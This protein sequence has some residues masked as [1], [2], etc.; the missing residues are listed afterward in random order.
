MFNIIVATDKNQGIGKNGKLPW[1]LRADMQFFKK[2]TTF[3]PESNMK[4]AVIMGRKTYESIPLKFRPL[5][6][7]LN[8]VLTKNHEYKQDNVITAHQ[9]DE[10]LEMLDKKSDIY[11]VFIIGGGEIYKEA[12]FHSQCKR[13]YR[14]V[15]NK[16]FNCDTFFPK[17]ESKF[18]L[19][20]ESNLKFENEISY[21]FQTW[22]K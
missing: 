16:N 22:S 2:T 8:I 4:N 19:E 11:N 18:Y 14:T 3:C 6:N 12:I 13:V 9:F 20:N 17:F 10:V 15:I 1:K 21:Q 7:R 5:N